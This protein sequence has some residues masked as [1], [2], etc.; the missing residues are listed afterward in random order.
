[1]K[2]IR[3]EIISTITDDKLASALLASTGEEFAKGLEEGTII[4][5]YI[6]EDITE[7]DEK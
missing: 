4:I 6:V 2:K 7:T 1:M 5:S 3:L